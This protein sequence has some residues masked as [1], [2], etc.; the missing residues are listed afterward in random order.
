MLISQFAAYKFFAI[1]MKN[2]PHHE[3]TLQIF[4]NVSRIQ[5]LLNENE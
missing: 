1:I 2:R 3:A 4:G 5:F